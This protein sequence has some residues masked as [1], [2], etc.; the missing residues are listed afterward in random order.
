MKKYKRIRCLV[1]LKEES[2]HTIKLKQVKYNQLSKIK[3]KSNIIRPIL[4]VLQ[5][6]NVKSIKKRT[7]K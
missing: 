5:E 2:I 1:T 7:K 4:S 6:K 3:N